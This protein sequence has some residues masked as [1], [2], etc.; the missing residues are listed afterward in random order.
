MP[1]LLCTGSESGVRFL[2][3]F[4]LNEMPLSEKAKVQ[5][6]KYINTMDLEHSNKLPSEEILADIIGVSRITIRSAL[7]DLASEGVIFR[8]QGKGT[9]VNVDSLS[10]KV[11]FNPISEFTTM[12]RDSGYTPSVRLLDM[13]II[14]Q[15]Q[16]IAESLLLEEGD[17]LVVAEKMFLADH[18]MC[19]YCADYFSLA[20]VGGK[21]NL[22]EMARFENSI[23]AYMFYQSARKIVWD[24]VEI[25]AEIG[26]RIPNLSKHTDIQELGD[27]AFLYLKGVNY[28]T[29]DKPAMYAQKYIDPDIIKFSMIRQRDIHY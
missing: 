18:K 24:K 28:D 13:K 5:I 6:R 21:Q 7:N 10:I 26:K 25:S 20:S 15:D 16:E 14:P 8:R 23:F 3:D 11:K 2:D 19:A 4:R 17:E 29:N 1:C 22:S 27:K 9:F 12:I